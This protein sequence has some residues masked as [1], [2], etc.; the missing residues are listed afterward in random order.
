MFCQLEILRHCL[1]SSVRRFLEELPESLDETYERVLREIKKPNRDHAR[2]LLQCLVVATR[3]LRVEELAEVV[4]VDF[5]DTEGIPKLKPSWRWDD[6]EQ[7]LLTSCSSLITIVETGGSRVVQFSHFSVKEFL[8]SARLGTS[9]Q[10]VSRYHI[11]LAPAHTI[12]AE[13][14][15]GIFLDDLIEDRS[16]ETRSP[17]SG[18]AAEYWVRHAQFEDVESRIKGI[19][20]LFDLDKPYFAAWCQF[21]DIDS[22]P[23][24]SVFYDFTAGVPGPT[25][26]L[27]TPVYYAALC[28]FSNLVE[29]LIVKYPQHV[30]AIGGHYLTPAV[31]ALDRRHFHLAQVLHR[32]GSS[33]EPRGREG[34]TPLHT[35]TFYG[36]LE[37]I[38]VLLDYGVN[39]NA[40]TDFGSNA[41]EFAS[42]G[43]RIVNPRV[44]RLLLDHGADPNERGL[45]GLT[46]LLRASKVGDI[47]MARLLVEHGA[48][49]E[50][51][52]G[53]GKTPLDYASEK[54]HEEVIKLLLEHGANRESIV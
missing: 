43:D 53:A 46:P 49:V 41:L 24:G 39:V 8:T 50:L 35:A 33:V 13:V 34:R 30:N 27:K 32:S 18:Y 47:E 29:Q 7:A 48:S 11:V 54:Q 36:N 3:P 14:C 22:Y 51:Q 42:W 44:A 26:G 17:L 25:S 38:Q 23:S 1:P 5:D 31:A 15:L 45:Y 52:D 6:Q 10:D 16:N 37:M 9:S 28:G 12:L 2:R 40:K 19:E 4:A 21:Q 20:Y